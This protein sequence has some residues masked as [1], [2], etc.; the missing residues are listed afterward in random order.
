MTPPSMNSIFRPVDGSVACTGSNPPGMDM[1]DRTASATGVSGVVSWL[2]VKIRS[3][4][5]LRSGW[6]ESVAF[7]ATICSG[8]GRSRKVTGR[9][10]IP[11]RSPSFWSK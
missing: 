7:M 3:R 9:S 10:W 5:L 6:A 4:G 11:V 1:E 8:N 2:K